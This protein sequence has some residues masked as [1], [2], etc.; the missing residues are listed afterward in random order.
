MFFDVHER[1][2]LSVVFV[3]NN[4]EGKFAYMYADKLDLRVH[5]RDG[6][7]FNPPPL[8]VQKPSGRFYIM[9]NCIEEI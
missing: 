6:N 7:I 1:K 8:L 4:E 2:K 5:I 3:Y 9:Y